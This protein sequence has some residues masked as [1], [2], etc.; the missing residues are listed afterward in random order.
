[1]KKYGLIG[2]TLR[3]SW[4]PQWFN[5]MFARCGIA[6]AEYNLY[7]MESPGDLHRWVEE[8]GIAGFN[9]TIPFKESVVPQMDRCDAAV[10][11][12]G[13]VNC[14]ECRDGLLIGHNTDAPAFGQT[15]EPLL[16]PWHTSALVLGT[17]GAAKAV[18]HALHVLGIECT[19]V[20]RNPE[21][22]PGAVSYHTAM[23]E[24][25][26]R[27]LI[28][29][30]TP[31]GMFPDID[32]SPWPWPQLLSSR[33][34]CYDL[35]YNPSPTLFLQQAASAGAATLGGLAMLHRQAELSW[36]IWK[37]KS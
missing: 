23:Q 33:H 35:V 24:V 19:F 15:L 13:A 36:Q 20:S 18:G 26:S 6:D 25:D 21:Q 8:C 9:V 7:E 10:Q 16:R 1:M 14:V 32:S 34:L 17:G 27:L 3:H 5:G 30:A 29:N 11:A 31:V 4:S 37:Q 22:H 2:K 12:I 28:V